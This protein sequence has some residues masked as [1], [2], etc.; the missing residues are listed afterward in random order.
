MLFLL[1][2]LRGTFS[3][4]RL[5]EYVTFRAAGAFL[6][7]FLLVALL[8]PLFLPFFRKHLTQKSERLDSANGGPVGDPAAPPKTR[9]P[10]MGGLLI[11]GAVIV[12]TVLW[13]IVWERM[14]AVFL[15]VLVV[16]TLLGMADDIIKVKYLR[17]ERDG[18]TERTKL[19]VQTL[20]T[21]L[22]VYLLYKTRG[23]VSM[24]VFF[25]FSKQPFHFS[26][27]GEMILLKLPYMTGAITQFAIQWMP[28]CL[29]VMLGFNAFVVTGVSNGVNL[30]DGK[31]GLAPGCLVFA[32]LAFAGVAYLYSHQV[33]ADYLDV[34]HSPRAGEVTVYACAI[35]GAC[36]GF[37]WHNASPAS[38]Y[39]GDTGS[40]ALGGALGMIGVLLGQQLLLPIIGFIFFVEAL[41][42]L[43]QR[44]SYRLRHGK[45]IF[46][47]APIHHHFEKLG[48]PDN[49][50]TV[51][52]WI[53]AGLAALIGVATLKMH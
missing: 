14:L 34:P 7:A 36:L 11:V 24:Q 27:E 2:Y 32:A 41:S 28:L 49:K 12:T 3:P 10:L 19:I 45:R 21:V 9:P 39:M 31:D 18:V 44:W 17:R 53:V 42:V 23:S 48:V 33:F 6:T 35:A 37:L 25:P 47:M 16:L 26:P 8:L 22:A 46:L 52:F 29:L 51:R 38:I 50:I 13:G 43:L 40:L 4:L 5:F 1:H 20:V 15:L 30:T